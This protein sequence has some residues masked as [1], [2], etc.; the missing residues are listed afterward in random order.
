M[1]QET[2]QEIT[3]EKQE[4]NRKECIQKSTKEQGKKV[5]HNSSKALGESMQKK[6][7]GIRQET[8]QEN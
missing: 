7:Q 8:M 6:Q 4:R 2:N 1:K 3:Q 5:C